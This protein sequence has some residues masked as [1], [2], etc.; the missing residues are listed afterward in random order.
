MEL[1]RGRLAVVYFLTFSLTL[2]TF[3]YLFVVGGFLPLAGYA[4]MAITNGWATMVAALH[5]AVYG[6]IFAWLSLKLAGL[7]LNK[8]KKRLMTIVL[9]IGASVSIGFLRIHGVGHN[10]SKFE[11]AYEA[12]ISGGRLSEK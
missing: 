2:P 12:C 10:S 5:A 7:S 4:S 9:V 8:Q 11:N 6:L 3:F 1:T